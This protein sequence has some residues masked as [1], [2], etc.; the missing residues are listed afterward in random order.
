MECAIKHLPSIWQ[1]PV[2]LGLKLESTLHLTGYCVHLLLFAL[3]L[4]Y[5]LVILLN[6]QYE[7][8]ITLFGIAVV[9]NIT[10]FA[11]TLFFILAQQQLGKRW[12]RSAPL[13]LLISAFGAGMMLNTVRA[14]L[15]MVSNQPGIFE[16]TPKFGILNRRQ[17]WVDHRYQLRLDPIVY[18]ELAFALF[19]FATMSLALSMHNWAIA[20]YAG[21]F[22]AGLLLIT[23]ITFTQAIATRHTTLKHLHQETNH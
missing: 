2:S 16:R 13:F 23:G 1:A 12:F 10:A 8:L 22:A 3:A 15:H 19:N 14:A 20:A 5:P 18:F 21:V 11:P 17:V 7:N 9:F 4:L 6:Q